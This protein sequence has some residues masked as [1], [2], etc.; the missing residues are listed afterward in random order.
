ML[1]RKDRT[2]AA[3]PRV[4]AFQVHGREEQ[5]GK[6]A[7]YVMQTFDNAAKADGRRRA[8]RFVLRAGIIP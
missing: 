6:R 5:R 7:T 3:R 1:P 2:R 4:R 8:R